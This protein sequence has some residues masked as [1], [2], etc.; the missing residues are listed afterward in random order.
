MKMFSIE[1]LKSRVAPGIRPLRSQMMNCYSRLSFVNILHLVKQN[2]TTDWMAFCTSLQ[3][4]IAA[5]EVSHIGAKTILEIITHIDISNFFPG[6]RGY[7]TAYYSY[8]TWVVPRSDLDIFFQPD[9]SPQ[10]GLHVYIFRPTTKDE[11]RFF[12]IDAFFGTLKPQ[13]DPELY[14]EFVEDPQG[15]NSTLR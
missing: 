10:P 5:D 9:S 8:V 4:K 6:T 3:K 7:D 14:G 2:I 1:N 13:T 11:N 12:A 15:W